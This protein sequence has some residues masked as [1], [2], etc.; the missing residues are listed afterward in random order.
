V[1]RPDFVGL[2][3]RRKSITA[4]VLDG[5]GDHLD[6]S[7]LGSRDRELFDNL[8]RLPGPLQVVLEAGNVWEHVRNA[9]ASTG[10][11]VLLARPFKTRIITGTSPKSG[12][13]DS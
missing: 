8:G 10:A 1:E 6:Q 11:R 12:K 5:N 7:K 3:V 9:V 2:D 4:T 13:M